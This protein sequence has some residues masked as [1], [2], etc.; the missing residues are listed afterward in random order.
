M[1]QK[2]TLGMVRLWESMLDQA[3]SG[4]MAKVNM[5]E[6][7]GQV[8]ARYQIEDEQGITALK[9]KLREAQSVVERLSETLVAMG[10]DL[11]HCRTNYSAKKVLDA[12]VEERAKGYHPAMVQAFV[13]E[14]RQAKEQIRL[15]VLPTEVKEV[16]ASI[17]ESADKIVPAL[18]AAEM[19]FQKQIALVKPDADEDEC[20]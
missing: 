17:R 15:S 11:S 1:A 10:V 9:A 5:V 8:L 4:V 12:A 14:V 7:R 20:E 3:V 18:E 16:L 13:A 19:G 6:A 2:V